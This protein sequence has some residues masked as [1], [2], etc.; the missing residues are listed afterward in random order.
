MTLALLRSSAIR[1][2][3]AS[4]SRH[5]NIT[6]RRL[7]STAATKLAGEE[8]SGGCPFTGTT[9]SS[10]S[11]ASSVQLTEI[12]ALPGVGSLVPMHSGIP[13][14]SPIDAQEFFPAMRKKFGDFYKMGLPGLGANNI[15]GDLY[16]LTDPEEMLKVVRQE[17]ASKNLY[18]VGFSQALWSVTR[19]Y[20]DRDWD[21]VK[22]DDVSN[23]LDEDGF[24]GR[25]EKWKRI[26]TFMQTDLLSPQAANGYMLGI[27]EAATHASQGAPASAHNPMDFLNRCSF[28]L[29]NTVLFGELTKA[30]NPETATKENLEFCNAATRGIQLITLVNANP[31]EILMDKLGFHGEMY[32]EMCKNLDVA[33][34][35]AHKKFDKFL[36]RYEEDKDSFTEV[37]RNTYL[38]RAIERQRMENSTVSQEE[39]ATI[40]KSIFVASVDTTSSILAWNLLHISMNPEVQEKLYEELIN[41]LEDGRVNESISKKASFPYLHAIVRESHRMTAPS[42]GG[43]RKE[44]A[45][46]VEIHGVK[47]PKGSMFVLDTYSVGVDPDIVDDPFVFKPERW[48]DDAV[49]ARKGTPAEVL[50]HPFYK[51]PFSQGSRRCPGSRVAANE[52]L[53]LLAQFVLDWKISAPEGMTTWESE[54]IGLI[55]PKLPKL[56]FEARS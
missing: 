9:S 23:P 21:F 1:A 7:L 56:S 37:E 26:R 42:I 14:I 38:Y 30:A 22:P 44:T 54:A 29:F 41:G 33:Y 50:D 46:E 19:Y 28:D 39:L 25:G 55:F 18:P 32:I 48:F 36:A 24:H 47:M 11:N 52:V 4:L 15:Y 27:V 5:A 35:L 49:E 6:N 31:K 43:L 51:A 10:S 12:K 40:M 8:V 16:V 13:N 2:F 34:T 53:I 3:H 20:Q 17:K 45:E